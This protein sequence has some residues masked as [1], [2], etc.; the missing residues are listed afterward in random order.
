MCVGSMLSFSCRQTV[1]VEM[2]AV[3]EEMLFANKV[4]LI[5][6]AHHHSYQRTCPVYRNKCMQPDADGYAGPVIVNLG[7]AGMSNRFVCVI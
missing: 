6:G 5:F 1:A 4:D 3:F 7:M 2:R